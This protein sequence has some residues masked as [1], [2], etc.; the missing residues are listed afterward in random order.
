M[1]AVAAV[2]ISAAGTTAVSCSLLTKVVASAVPLKSTV[3]VERKPVPFTVKVNCGPPGETALGTS[4][5][6][7]NGTGLPVAVV[8]STAMLRKGFTAVAPAPSVSCTQK[9]HVPPSA[10][11][12]LIVPVLAP[13]LSPFGS[14]P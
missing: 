11:V 6:L 4:G 12:P 1:E 14:A 3:E 2:A 10:G 13:R 8:G 5:W 7:R 9:Y